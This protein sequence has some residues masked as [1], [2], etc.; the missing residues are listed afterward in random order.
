MWFPFASCVALLLDF[1]CFRFALLRIQCSNYQQLM[2]IDLQQH[3]W[4]HAMRKWP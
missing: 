4:H 1:Q 2:K 3:C